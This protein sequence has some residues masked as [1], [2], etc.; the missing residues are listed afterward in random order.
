MMLT[1]R[2][3][4]LTVSG[5]QAG[6]LHAARFRRLEEVA[7]SVVEG[8]GQEEDDQGRGQRRHGADEADPMVSSSPNRKVGEAVAERL[9]EREAREDE[10]QPEIGDAQPQE[11]HQQLREPLHQQPAMPRPAE[12]ARLRVGFDDLLKALDH[13]TRSRGESA[14]AAAARWRSPAS[15]R[16]IPLN[17][18]IGRRCSLPPAARRSSG[19]CGT[20]SPAHRANLLIGVEIPFE[21]VEEHRFADMQADSP[22]AVDRERRQLD[23]LFHLT[24]GRL[25]CA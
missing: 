21:D 17:S 20:L 25:R 4:A 10:G 6:H 11:A 7:E 14:T 3:V 15:D 2:W 22:P 24:A 13:P 23:R 16:P 18:T 12:A 19:H 8:L 9:G 5:V 1:M